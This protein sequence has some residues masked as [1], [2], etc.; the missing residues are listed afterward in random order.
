LEDGGTGPYKAVVTGEASL[1]GD[2]VFRPQDL[3]VAD[4]N[5]SEYNHLGNFIINCISTYLSNL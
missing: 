1:P 5:L 2:T 4:D 3:L